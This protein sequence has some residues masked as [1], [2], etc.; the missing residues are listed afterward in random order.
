MGTWNIWWKREGNMVSLQSD[1]QIRGE[2]SQK[3]KLASNLRE[4][5]KAGHPSTPTWQL[6]ISLRLPAPIL[7]RSLCSSDHRRQTGGEVGR[8]S[9][10]PRGNKASG[11][12]RGCYWVCVSH[13]LPPSISASAPISSL[14]LAPPPLPPDTHISTVAPPPLC[15]WKLTAKRWG[16][17]EAELPANLLFFLITD[18]KLSSDAPPQIDF[19][20]LC[21]AIWVKSSLRACLLSVL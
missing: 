7:P 9:G 8:G 20:W 5:R 21:T 4:Q 6:V 11:R 10:G 18:P 12:G 19:R 14:P 15:H 16:L 13:P 1:M 2:T 17:V 3:L